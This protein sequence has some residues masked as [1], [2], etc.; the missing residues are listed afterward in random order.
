MTKAFE[1]FL[2]EK[3]SPSVSSQKLA[4]DSRR[5]IFL[6]VALAVGLWGP[7]QAQA[8]V[9]VITYHNDNSRTGQNLNE[10]LLTPANVNV[11]QF[12]KLYPGSATLDSWA[13]AQPLYVPNVMIGGTTH[14]VVYVATL[15]NSIFAFDADS[16]LEIWTARYGP[17]TPFDDLCTDSSYQVSTTRG[18]GIVSTPVID[19]VAGVLYFVTKNGNGSPTQPFALN[20]HAVDFTTG[21]EETSL[22]SPVLISPPSGP[23]FMPQY[24]MNRPGLLLNNG[25]VYVGLGSTGCKGLNGFPKINNHGWVLG[26]STLSL[27]Q[28]PTVFVTSPATNNSGV[29]QAGGGLAA[30]GSGNIYFETADGVFDANNGGSDYGLSVLK[31]DPNLNFLDYFTPYNE[32]TLLEP[33]DLDLSSVGPL[34]LPDPQPGQYPHLLV[35]SGKNEEIYLLDRDGMGEFCGTCTNGTN[36]TNIPQDILPP[37]SL[38]GCLGSGPGFTCRYGTPSFWSNSSSNY[39]YFAEVPGPLLAYSLT[40]GSLS[41][42]PTSQSPLNYSG[43]GSPS[44]SA[45]GTSSGI[46][47]AVTW[48]NGPPGQNKGT[49]RAFDATNLQTQFYASSLATGNRD[50]LGYVPNF[51]TPTIANGKVFVATQT[52]LLVFGLLPSLTVTAGNNQ[53]GYVGTSLP[54]TLSVQALSSYTGQPVANAAI[55]FAAVPAG[56][57]F[58]SPTAITNSAGIATTTYILPTKPGAVTITASGSSSSTTTAYFTETAN[59]GPPASMVLVSGGKQ[60][61]TVG[62][63]LPAPIVVSVKDAFGNAVS[64]VPVEFGGKVGG[65]F[66]PDPV[67]SNSLGEAS[68]YYTLPTKASM[69]TLDAAITG[70]EIKFSEQSIAASPASVNLVAGNNQS[71][72]PNTL[73]PQPL[74]VNV[75]DQY[76]NLISGAT[77]SFTDNGANGTLSSSSVITTANG[78]ATVTYVTPPQAGTVTITASILGLTPVNFTETVQ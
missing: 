17:P 73:L 18:A 22:G 29:W 10:T 4:R 7:P 58:G 16:G 52:Q 55:A 69:L 70:F 48:A 26:Y 46:L 56:G 23:T 72:P 42:S 60:R 2:A 61:G 28:P 1:G 47:W 11:S 66:S 24:Q 78:Q 44:I 13:P 30:D 49:L 63:T 76:G 40:A 31:L 62:T 45:N 75:E 64:A 68:S 19:P 21:I 57:T 37:T 36:N 32:A 74:V 53:S 41:A 51:I 33:Y 14:N 34:L 5:T 54:V 8:Q 38:S 20:L 25:V 9:S 35:A 27:T 6:A 50:A 43:E 77:V 39:I 12:G 59:A 71:E 15:N 65:T 3:C 67:N